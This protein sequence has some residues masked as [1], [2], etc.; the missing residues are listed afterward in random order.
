MVRTRQHGQQNQLE[1]A[2][3]ETISITPLPLSLVRAPRIVSSLFADTVPC[4]RVGLFVPSF[5]R[6]SKRLS[7]AIPHAMNL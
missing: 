1:L 7:T 6:S 5:F 2:V 3:R 4:P